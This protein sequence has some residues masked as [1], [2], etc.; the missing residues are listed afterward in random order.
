MLL[1]QLYYHVDDE[2]VDDD[3]FIDFIFLKV[4]YFLK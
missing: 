3:E 1:N 2:D 4:I